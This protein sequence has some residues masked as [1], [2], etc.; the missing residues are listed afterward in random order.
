MQNTQQPQQHATPIFRASM[1]C[2]VWKSEEI[3]RYSKR[4]NDFP[5]SLCF[6]ICRQG[7]CLNFVFDK[8]NIFI[9]FRRHFNP[10]SS[11]KEISSVFSTFST[12][13]FSSHFEANVV[14]SFH[15][16]I[17][18][19]EKGEKEKFLNI[20]CN[21]KDFFLTLLFK[22]KFIHIFSI[23]LKCGAPRWGWKIFL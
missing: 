7:E 10:I 1:K 20:L 8:I 9:L 2:D 5:I 14:L 21:K 15:T 18:I 23:F 16:Q 11:K 13:F 6:L 17:K 3:E 22:L 12:L 4:E 19:H